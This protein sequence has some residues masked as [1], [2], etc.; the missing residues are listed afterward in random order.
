MKLLNHILFLLFVFFIRIIFDV[1]G[2]WI[3]L[4]PQFIFIGCIIIGLIIIISPFYIAKIAPDVKYSF[5]SIL[6]VSIL[7][8]IVECVFL[9]NQNYPL[10]FIFFLYSIIIVTTISFILL[11]K[12]EFSKRKL[13]ENKRNEV[14]SNGGLKKLFSVSVDQLLKILPED[15][16]ISEDSR[17][18]PITL[19]FKLKDTSQHPLFRLLYY[20]T[21]RQDLIFSGRNPENQYVFEF[22]PEKTIWIF[23]YL[24]NEP[25][26]N[27]FKKHIINYILMNPVIKRNKFFGTFLT[28]RVRDDKELLRRGIV[29]YFFKQQM[30]FGNSLSKEDIEEMC[31]I[32]KELNVDTKKYEDFMESMQRIDRLSM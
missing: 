2:N 8:T 10:K 32:I 15:V 25:N 22:V 31:N 12:R 20:P 13:F 6:I 21:A 5:Y 9:Y 24:P 3:I 4:H 28:V 14:L 30:M 1:I 26:I 27:E 18:N 19:S 11:I 23:G 17:Y 7:M 29:H 16:I